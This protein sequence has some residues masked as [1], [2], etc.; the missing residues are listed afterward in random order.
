[1]RFSNCREPLWNRFST[2]KVVGLKR[3]QKPGP[4]FFLVFETYLALGLAGTRISR[5]RSVRV[6]TDMANQDN[7]FFFKKIM[8]FVNFHGNFQA[9]PNF[10]KTWQ[11]NLQKYIFFK[12]YEYFCWF[13]KKIGR[14][15]KK[16]DHFMAFDNFWLKIPAWQCCSV[17]RRLTW[18][19]KIF[20]WQPFVQWFGNR[21][22]VIW[23]A[24]V[25]EVSR[26]R[27]QSTA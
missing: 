4:H 19:L 18:R 27:V 5:S 8:F 6:V 20:W 17:F 11:L 22:G 12:S 13:S 7:E 23:T 26:C 9:K 25:A 16:Q 3:I 14:E 10:G 15:Y 21:L 2:R 24:G 1:M